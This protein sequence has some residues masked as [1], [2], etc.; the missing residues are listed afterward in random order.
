[1][2]VKNSKLNGI[3]A[4]HTNYSK[5]FSKLPGNFESIDNITKAIMMKYRRPVMKLA[6]KLTEHSCP[7][8]LYTLKQNFRQK[9]W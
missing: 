4:L 1:M 9:S 6:D 2:P 3:H 8:L 5:S 7:N